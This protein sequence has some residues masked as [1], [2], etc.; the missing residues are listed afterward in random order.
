MDKLKDKWNLLV[1]KV[2][3][4]KDVVIRVTAAV[5][6]AAVVATGVAV[7]AHLQ[8]RNEVDLIDVQASDVEEDEEEIEE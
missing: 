2:Q 5:A 6:V 1:Q 4:N 7:A 8:A 3:E